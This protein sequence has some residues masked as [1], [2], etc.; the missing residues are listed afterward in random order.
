MAKSQYE[1]V[2]EFH[3]KFGIDYNGPCRILPPDLAKFREAFLDEELQEYRDAVAEGNHEKALDSLVDLIYIALGTA[4]VHGYRK[5][6]QAFN[7]VHN[8]NMQ[9]R[10]VMKQGESRRNDKYD[11]VKPDGW[12][13]PDLSDL[14]KTNG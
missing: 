2:V 13:A 6:D 11:I 8:A 9:K 5:F 1:M 14:V 10:R 4:H 12:K 3:K 7:R